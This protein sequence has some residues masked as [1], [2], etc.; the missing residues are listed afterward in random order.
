MNEN[1]TQNERSWD[2]T[3]RRF[4]SALAGIEEIDL[5][6]ETEEEEEEQL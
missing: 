5:E 4:E 2:E 6:V 1:T 3:I